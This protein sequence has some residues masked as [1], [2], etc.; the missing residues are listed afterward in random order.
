[1]TECLNHLKLIWSGDGKMSYEEE[2]RQILAAPIE[3][4]QLMNNI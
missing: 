3:E 1:V 4:T 2:E